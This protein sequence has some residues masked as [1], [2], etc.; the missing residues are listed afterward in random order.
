M[1]VCSLFSGCG[2]MDLG[3][4]RAGFD[5]VWANEFNSQCWST[6]ER[7]HPNTELC[8][9]NILNLDYATIPDCDG[10][11]GGPP[12]QSWSWAGEMGGIDDPRGILFF[13]FIK[14]LRIKQPSFFV[15]E[16]VP[17][18]LT[19]KHRR[20]YESIMRRLKLA[21]YDVFVEQLNAKNYGVP[22]DRKRVFFIGFL[23]DLEV[24]FTF[25]T[26]LAREV[27]VR[28]AIG[29]LQYT[30]HRPR[31]KNR[32]GR[33]RC[34][35]PNHEYWQGDYSY[36]FMSRNRVLSWDKAAYT[37]QASGRQVSIHPQ[38][39]KM[40]PV[41]R[42]VMCFDQK[43]LKKYRRLSIRECARIQTFPD[44]F[45]FDYDYLEHGYKMVGNAVP[46]NLAFRIAQQIRRQPELEFDQNFV[47]EDLAVMAY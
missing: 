42:D 34:E 16:N 14:V 29:D 30:V 45:I 10:L 21:G 3:F 39:P 25:P 12:C 33:D 44:D 4:T 43:K 6:Y 28:D 31:I 23:K 20:A 27:S 38:A 40:I 41:G 2:G 5:V 35:V 47:E 46:V 17:G 1:I 22:Q 11:I 24:D 37:V 9:E 32:S 26:P 7:N 15:I 19:A 13:E 18:I 8:R 36:I